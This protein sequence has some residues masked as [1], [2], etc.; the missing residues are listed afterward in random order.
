[1]ADKQ[2]TLILDFGSQ[3]T[4]LIAR[5]VRQLR[6]YCEIHPHSMPLDAIK[7][8]NPQA[9]I[10]SG[11]PSSVNDDGAPEIDEFKVFRFPAPLRVERPLQTHIFRSQVA[12][13]D[14]FFLQMRVLCYR[15][16]CFWSFG[17]LGLNRSA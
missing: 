10:L 17:G 7:A 13:R 12:V 9:I 2:T 14:T 16:A 1:M 8:L 6:I 3:Y 4:Q 15:Y 11:G 5:R